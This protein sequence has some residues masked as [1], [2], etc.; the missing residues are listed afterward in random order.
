M[1]FFLNILFILLKYDKIFQHY[2]F[3]II[4]LFIFVIVIIIFNL[5]QLIIKLKVLFY[6]M[7]LSNK[8]LIIIKILHKLFYLPCYLYFYI[9]LLFLKFL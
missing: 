8:I 4:I 9:N 1:L 5:C 7:K 2:I 3:H 6:E